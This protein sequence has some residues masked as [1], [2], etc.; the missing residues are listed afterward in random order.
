MPP[1]MQTKQIAFPAKLAPFARPAPYKICHGG[2]GGAKSWSIA[3]LLLVE[4]AAKKLRVLC[5]REYQNSI[6]DSV[7]QLLSDQVEQLGLRAH[8][9]INEKKIE[10]RNGT[11]FRFFGLR[12]QFNEIASY[13]G[14][15]RCWVEEAV[16]VSKASW[17]KLIPT[18]RKEGSEIWVSFNPSLETDETYKRFVVDPPPGA[19]VVKLNYFDNPWFPQKLRDEMNY[20][21]GKDEDAFLNIWEGFCRRVLDGA[22]FAKEMRDAETSNR[23]CVVPLERGVP[24]DTIWDLGRSDMTS[25]WFRQRVGFEFRFIDFYENCGY[26]ITHYLE[27]LQGRG[28]VLGHIYLPHDAAAQQLGSRL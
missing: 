20:L 19:V 21:R 17:E 9:N 22:I 14:I 15:D 3:R 23:I 4:G 7:H 12:K 6:A 10:G 28:Y 11:K 16:T 5:A 24:V 2:R 25:I 13:E 1:V 18:I 27:T 8:Y 26:D